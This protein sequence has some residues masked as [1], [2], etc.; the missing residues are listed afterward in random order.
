MGS[1]TVAEPVAAGPVAAGPVAAGPVAAGPVAA[2]PVAAGP[3]S[4]EPITPF[5]ALCERLADELPLRKDSD[6]ARCPSFQ[7]EMNMKRAFDNIKTKPGS[8]EIYACHPP[9][10]N[11]LYCALDGTVW[12]FEVYYQI[13][14][15]RSIVTDDWP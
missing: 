6:M 8:Y 1:D 10:S 13:P 14:E 9:M 3:V 15:T 5:I 4:A 11:A 2:G 7:D 12:M